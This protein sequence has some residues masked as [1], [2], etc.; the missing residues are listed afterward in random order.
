MGEVMLPT[1]LAFGVV[2][3]VLLL[4]SVALVLY[5]RGPR[6]SVEANLALAQARMKS[7]Q[8]ERDSAQKRCAQLLAQNDRLAQLAAREGRRADLA[9]NA[10][11]S[12]AQR[13]R[14]CTCGVG[15]EVVA[16][17]EEASNG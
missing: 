17:L 3:F 15:A 13:L 2:V 16:E 14:N 10:I 11:D 9:L 4:G 7:A 5:G 12:A 6:P 1:A 8:N